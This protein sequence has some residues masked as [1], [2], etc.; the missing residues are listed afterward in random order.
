M[1]TA[2]TC[3]VFLFTGY[4]YHLQVGN[5]TLQVREPYFGTGN[6][7]TEALR[8][9]AV[10]VR[11][12]R[13]SC[14]NHILPATSSS[15]NNADS[16]TNSSGS[17]SSVSGSTPIRS[18]ITDDGSSCVVIDRAGI[19]SLRAL[20]ISGSGAKDHSSDSELR[21]DEGDIIVGA[22]PPDPKLN[23]TVLVVPRASS[24]EMLQQLLAPYHAQH[25][26]L[27]FSNVTDT[28]KAFEEQG[29][30]TEFGQLLRALVHDWC[31][32]KHQLV[33]D[34]GQP[35]GHLHAIRPWGSQQKVCARDVRVKGGGLLH[36]SYFCNGP[37]DYDMVQNQTS[38][39]TA[40]GV[41]TVTR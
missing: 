37:H 19:T 38:T 9:S 23:V 28:F 31:C 5:S 26:W 30:A 34:E 17:S 22:A 39:K 41:A 7:H 12:G 20:N 6:P 24:G 33:V 13:P 4:S 16:S 2:T 29:T 27:H 21:A 32:R 36:N 25:Q 40:A 35:T 18:T 8:R 10:L 11:P 1:A 15:W 3:Y 14:P